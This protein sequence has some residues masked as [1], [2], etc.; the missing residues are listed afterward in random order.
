MKPASLTSNKRFKD[1]KPSP[2]CHNLTTPLRDPEKLQHLNSVDNKLYENYDV[3]DD[4]Y[5]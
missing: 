2:H 5:T 1:L 3:Y 4:G